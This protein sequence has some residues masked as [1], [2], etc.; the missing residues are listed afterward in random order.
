MVSRP[1]FL[2]LASNLV[3]SGEESLYGFCVKV[4]L[5]MKIPGDKYHNLS[6]RTI[7]ELVDEYGHESEDG[8]DDAYGSFEPPSAQRAPPPKH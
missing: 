8:I 5:N 7:L 1:V 4:S 2:K 3:N 6:V